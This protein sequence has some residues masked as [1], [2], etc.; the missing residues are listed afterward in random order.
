MYLYLRFML[1]KGLYLNYVVNDCISLKFFQVLVEQLLIY[2]KQFR[3]PN[4]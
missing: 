2:T 1:R 3:I 4:V